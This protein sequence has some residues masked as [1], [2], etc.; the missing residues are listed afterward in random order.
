MIAIINKEKAERISPVNKN[1]PAKIPIQAGILL[2]L[3]LH[4][5][6]IEIVRIADGTPERPAECVMM[7]ITIPMKDSEIGTID[8]ILLTFL[9]A[10]YRARDM[11]PTR[12]MIKI[13]KRFNT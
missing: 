13:S 12:H 4:S 11:M 3:L 1:R 9:R 5:I 10:G 8:Q 2:K 7:K 6:M